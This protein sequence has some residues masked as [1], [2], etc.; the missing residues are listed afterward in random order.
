M[1]PFPYH[2]RAFDAEGNTIRQST[3]LYAT[4]EEARNA[5]SAFDRKTGDQH[6]VCVSLDALDQQNR[7]NAHGEKLGFMVYDEPK[8]VKTDKGDE[9]DNRGN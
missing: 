4:V 2:F 5:A 3:S 9:G 1:R 6:V 7:K 8:N